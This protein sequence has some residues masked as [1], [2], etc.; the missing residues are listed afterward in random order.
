MTWRTELDI[1]RKG[2]LYQ[3]YPLASFQYK[4]DRPSTIRSSTATG[5]TSIYQHELTG[6]IGNICFD[7]QR[8]VCGNTETLC[9]TEGSMIRLAV[10]QDDRYTYIC[11]LFTD[12][13]AYL[14]GL[15]GVCFLFIQC[16]GWRCWTSECTWPGRASESQFPPQLIESSQAVQINCERRVYLWHK[17]VREEDERCLLVQRA[18]VP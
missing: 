13:D 18:S 14:P 8:R 15:F 1:L 12:T 6:P 7:K 2:R 16:A 4:N 11:F 3:K 17:S 5:L 9:E 10:E